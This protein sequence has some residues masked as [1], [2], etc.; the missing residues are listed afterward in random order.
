MLHVQHTHKY[1][2]GDIMS[3]NHA[4]TV[5]KTTAKDFHENLILGELC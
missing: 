1:I 5:E 4:A 2:T 3:A